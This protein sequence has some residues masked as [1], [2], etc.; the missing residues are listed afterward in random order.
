MSG[1]PGLFAYV[2]VGD[3]QVPRLNHS[4]D[5]L[6]HFTRC[7]IV[8]VASRCT[9]PIHHE[10]VLRPE[11]ADRWDDHRAS[12]L[13]K[14]NLYRVLGSPQ[15][16]CC[17]L[18]SDV[19]A[20]D[21]QV[22]SIFHQKQGPVTFA[23]DHV[24]LAEFS[25]YA[26]R[27]GCQRGECDHLRQ[28]IREKFGIGVA[29]PNW[30]H[31]N[32]GVFVFGEE[33]SGFLETWHE[34]TQTVFDDPYWNTRDQGTLVATAWKYGLENQP[35]LDGLFNYIVDPLRNLPISDS[36]RAGM[37]PPSY[38]VDTTYSLTPNGSVP[39]PHFVH[40]V[41]GSVGASGWK[42]W[43]DAATLLLHLKTASA[44]GIKN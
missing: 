29:D 37:R 40:F 21:H 24:R 10:Q 32:G 27:C 4:L 23:P 39:H 1:T 31:W 36:E 11:V 14:T 43:D 20:I 3:H 2:I 30:Q 33:S 12:I 34:H 18:D 6:K 25:R 15:A 44:E 38:F 16:S 19:I 41:N 35:T 7:D 42:N 13:L 8:V 22:D 17:Y 9:L 26:V 5:F 28:A